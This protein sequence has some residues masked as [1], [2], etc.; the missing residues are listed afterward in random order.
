MRKTR[1]IRIFWQ[2]GV[3]ASNIVFAIKAI[4]KVLELAKMD[5]KIEIQKDKVFDPIV[6]RDE[7][8]KSEFFGQ[9][10]AN[11][12]LDVFSLEQQKDNYD[13]YYTVFLIKDKIFINTD[14]GFKS[15]GGVAQRGESAIVCVGYDFMAVYLGARLSSTYRLTIHEIGHMFGLIS[16]ERKGKIKLSSINQSWHCANNCIMHPDP[17]SNK[18]FNKNIFCSICLRELRNY[19]KEEITNFG[20]ISP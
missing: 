7:N 10:N 18:S 1:P 20:T 19:F 14:E 12:I 17:N 6:Y 15:I 13:K 16:K 9:Y 3:T 8:V 2:D 4:K 11:G 5:G